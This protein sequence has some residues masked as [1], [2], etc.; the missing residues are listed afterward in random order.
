MLYFHY[1]FSEDKIS[2]SIYF[3]FSTTPGF[4]SINPV[5]YD[6]LLS[7]VFASLKSINQDLLTVIG[8]SYKLH[9]VVRLRT[10]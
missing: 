3:W 8:S 5:W 4:S 7:F 1:E 9:I 10:I 2:P 6:M